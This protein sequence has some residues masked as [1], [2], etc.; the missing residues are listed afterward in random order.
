MYFAGFQNKICYYIINTKQK[1]CGFKCLL[2]LKQILK[3][4]VDQYKF[5]I[6][7]LLYL[8]VVAA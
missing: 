2:D 1:Y 6:S 4:S 3:S 8:E 7:I 5:K